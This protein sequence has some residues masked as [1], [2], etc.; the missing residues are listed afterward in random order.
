MGNTTL[1]NEQYDGNAKAFRTQVCH[2][3]IDECM[4]NKKSNVRSVPMQATNGD[5]VIPLTQT[6]LR[7]QNFLAS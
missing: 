7:E 3:I 2:L 4:M 6:W 1:N 5:C